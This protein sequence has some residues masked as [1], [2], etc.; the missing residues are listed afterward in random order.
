ML[1]ISFSATSFNQING[2]SCHPANIN[3]ALT[4]GLGWSQFGVANNAPL[5]SSAFYVVCPTSY[6]APHSGGIRNGDPIQFID[7]KVDVTAVFRDNRAEDVECFSLYHTVFSDFYAG[8]RLHGRRFASLFS[9]PNPGE[10]GFQDNTGSSTVIELDYPRF[11]GHGDFSYS[12]TSV[13]C[14]L[15]PQTGISRIIE[16]RAFRQPA[17]VIVP[18]ETITCDSNEFFK[19]YYID[20][21]DLGLPPSVSTTSVANSDSFSISGIKDVNNGIIRLQAVVAGIGG[22][23]YA[24]VI[25]G[26]S[27]PATDVVVSPS[28]INSARGVLWRSRVSI[29]T[30]PTSITFDPIILELP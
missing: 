24:E 30:T 16:D 22:A 4:L 9:I 13:I 6:G 27:V 23:A 21:T 17:Q 15:P 1:F 20:D 26:E 3:Q 29:T 11:V 25:C 7:H 2:A 28:F 18:S 10:S 19:N 8:T 5:G 14:A 12:A